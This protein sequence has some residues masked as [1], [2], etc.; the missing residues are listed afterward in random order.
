MLSFRNLA[1]GPPVPPHLASSGSLCLTTRPFTK[2]APLCSKTAD[3]ASG[4]C[5]QPSEGLGL[6]PGSFWHHMHRTAFVT[7]PFPPSRF[8]RPKRR[9]LNTSRGHHLPKGCQCSLRGQG[10][11]ALMFSSRSKRFTGQLLELY[12]PVCQQAC[13]K[14]ACSLSNCSTFCFTL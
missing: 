10:T 11:V 9:S 1:S 12:R 6:V 4:S 3:R 7:P 14:A 2:Q 8:S 13:V 5:P